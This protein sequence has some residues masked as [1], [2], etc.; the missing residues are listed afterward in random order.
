[1]ESQIIFQTTRQELAQMAENFELDQHLRP[2][3]FEDG[4]DEF[5]GFIPHI[6][7]TSKEDSDYY[8]EDEGLLGLELVE[9]LELDHLLE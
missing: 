8:E 2:Y 4:E 5:E 3:G 6:P 7:A 9:S 1:M